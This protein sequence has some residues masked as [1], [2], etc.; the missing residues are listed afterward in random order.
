MIHFDCTDTE[1]A[2]IRNIV[3]RFVEQCKCHGIKRVKRIDLA[4]DIIACHC[5][6]CPLDLEA[7]ACADDFHLTH[8]VVGIVQHLDRTSGL[9]NQ[10]FLPRFAQK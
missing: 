3:D 10:H 4:M 5:N 6:G 1:L 9:L 7:L 8:D 2:L